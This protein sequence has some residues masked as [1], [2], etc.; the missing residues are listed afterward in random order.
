MKGTILCMLFK[1]GTMRFSEL[2]KEI[3]EITSRIL[4]KQLKNW[5]RWDDP[6][7]SG[8]QWKDKVRILPY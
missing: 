6:Q 7:G 3:G 5:R 8:H 4:T 2:Q 1:N